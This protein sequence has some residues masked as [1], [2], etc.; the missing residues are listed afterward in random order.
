MARLSHYQDRFCIWPGSCI[1]TDL[2]Q[3]TVFS[4]GPVNWGVVRP[5]VFS[6]AALEPCNCVF[7][8]V[9][10]R[11]H[12]IPAMRKFEQVSFPIGIIDLAI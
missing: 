3:A 7:L 9:Q 4:L 11:L 1:K 10:T 6:L 2:P 5:T 12:E 8:R